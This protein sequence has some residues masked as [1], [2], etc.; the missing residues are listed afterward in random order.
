MSNVSEK[1]RKTALKLSIIEISNALL[2]IE[3][4]KEHIK[5][6]VEMISSEYEMDKAVVR[7][8][9]NMYHKQNSEVVKSKADVLIDEYENIFGTDD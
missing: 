9:A 4:H 6:V 7:S 5:S 2:Q 1:S 8:L 3:S